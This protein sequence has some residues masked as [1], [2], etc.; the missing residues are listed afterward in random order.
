MAADVARSAPARRAPGAGRR[1]ARPRGGRR[2]RPGRLWQVDER[3]VSPSVMAIHMALLPTGKVIFFAFPFRPESNPPSD[4]AIAG[5]AWLWDPAKGNPDSSTSADP[6]SESMFT[7]VVPPYDP[8]TDSPASLFCAGLALMANGDLMTVGGTLEFPN[9]NEAYHYGLKRTYTFNPWTETWVQQPDMQHGRWYPSLVELP[10]G[11]MAVLAG[12]NEAG[13]GNNNQLEV[14]TPTDDPSGVGSWQ[15]PSQGDRQTDLYPHMTLIGDGKVLLAG[16]GQN[17][18]GL[19]DPATMTWTNLPAQDARRTYGTELLDPNGTGPSTTVTEIGG[20]PTRAGPAPP[21]RPWRRA[22]RSTCRSTRRS[23]RPGR[24]CRSPVRTT[25]RSGCRTARSSRSAAAT[26][27]RTAAPTC[28]RTAS[29]STRSSCTTPS[30]PRTAGCSAPRSRSTAPTTPPRCC[31]PTAACCR[32]ATTTPTSTTRPSAARRTPTR[33]RTTTRA[34]S[35]RRPICSAAHGRR[36]TR[37][38]S[39]RTTAPS[40]TSPSARWTRSR[41]T[42]C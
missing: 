27:C 12:L 7:H 24:R 18:T 10:D 25:T 23:G 5:D 1:G 38:P 11:R 16:P 33:A 39:P 17:D 26:A 42:R 6:C 40:S 19:L 13:T 3:A 30:T 34:R 21:S 35:T 4:A 37:L 20:F 29:R 31:C 9:P 28:S 2:A 36:S 41:R 22:S 14:F 8:Q 15:H 32:R